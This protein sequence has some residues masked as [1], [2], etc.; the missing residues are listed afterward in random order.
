MLFH[1]L[2]P[3]FEVRHV[4]SYQFQAIFPLIF[5]DLYL[6]SSS[7]SENLAFLAF[8]AIP[9]PE[10]RKFFDFHI[11]TSFFSSNLPL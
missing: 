5:G 6:V 10:F 3:V 1:T 9:V 8:L 2:F 4:S 11:G 7:V